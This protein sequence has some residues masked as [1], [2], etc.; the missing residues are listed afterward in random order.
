MRAPG[1]IWS[2]RGGCG[3]LTIELADDW[4][5]AWNTVNCLTRG[6]SHGQNKM[7][8]EDKEWRYLVDSIRVKRAGPT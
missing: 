2:Q 8:Y 6:G 5:K 1:A 7:L 3:E 4:G